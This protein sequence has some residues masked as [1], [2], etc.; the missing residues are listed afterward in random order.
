MH[1][2]DAEQRWNGGSYDVMK[3]FSDAL[4]W[5]SALHEKIPLKIFAIFRFFM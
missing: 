3:V 5:Y 4:S 2:V 1:F